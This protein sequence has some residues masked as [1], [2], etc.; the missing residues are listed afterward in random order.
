MHESKSTQE[1]H[2]NV[3]AKL[4]CMTSANKFKLIF[5]KVAVPHNSCNWYMD[6]IK[7]FYH[8]IIQKV[9]NLKDNDY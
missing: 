7:K 6:Y 4:N 8:L 2:H 5:I 1:P 3:S 9:Y